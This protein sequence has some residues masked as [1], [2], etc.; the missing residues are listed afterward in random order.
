MSLGSISP[1][2]HI[3][4]I[5]GALRKL[6]ERG[7]KFAADIYG[8]P[9]DRDGYYYKKIRALAAP[10]EKK[11]VIV[12]CPAVPNHETPAIYSVHDIF[13]NATPQGSFDKTILEAAL[14][15]ALPVVGNAALA[16]IFPKELLFNKGEVADL[17]AAIESVVTFSGEKREHIREQLRRVVS[18]N[19]GLNIL[20][21]DVLVILK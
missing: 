13:I 7:V 12:F 11:E 18:A 21:R 17:A 20:V 8:D 19:H 4:V 9:T 10:L 14:C 6:D 5:I 16:D 1:V 2:K 3:E 15:G